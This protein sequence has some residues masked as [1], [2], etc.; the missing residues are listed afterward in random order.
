MIE[1]LIKGLTK[2]L[3]DNTAALYTMQ[4]AGIAPKTAVTTTMSAAAE[5]VKAA[6]KPKAA[7]KSK[8]P[9]NVSELGD[10]VIAYLNVKGD[11]TELQTRKENV[12]AL[13][14][15][16]G[17]KRTTE[18]EQERWPE[19][20]KYIEELKETGRASFMHGNDND[21]DDEDESLV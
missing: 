16:F 10:I 14:Q 4:K 18:V 11:V 1:E 2:A 7:A 21:G 5:E 12:A 20:V 8:G 3:E 6:A 13:N 17:V 19:I 15:F 9:K